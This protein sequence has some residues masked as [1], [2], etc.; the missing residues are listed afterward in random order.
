LARNVILNVRRNLGPEQL[1]PDKTGGVSFWNQLQDEKNIPETWTTQWR[2]MVLDKCMNRARQELDK[3]TFSAFELLALAE[4]PVE[5][6]ADKLGMSENA[7]YIAK[8]R[9]LTRLRQLEEEFEGP[10]EGAKS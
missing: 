7:V 3:K 6:V 5:K 2:K 1:I 8:S 10:R 9:V 4:L